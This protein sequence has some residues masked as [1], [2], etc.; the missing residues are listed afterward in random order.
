M[1][2]SKNMQRVRKVVRVRRL[3]AIPNIPSSSLVENEDNKEA[4]FVNV[5]LSPKNSSLCE[6]HPSVVPAPMN[7]QV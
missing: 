2:T 6:T 4:L 3:S 5:S 1:N 7:S